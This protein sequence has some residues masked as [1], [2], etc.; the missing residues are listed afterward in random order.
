MRVV[1]HVLLHA[2]DSP[3]AVAV[4][5]Q[6][7]DTTYSE[8]AAQVKQ[9][10]GLLVQQGVTKGQYVGIM[11]ER[12]VPSASQPPRASIGTSLGTCMS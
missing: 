10:S 9:I 2:R 12:S 7:Q 5:C 6:G 3:G 8:L 4:S 1:D 11:L